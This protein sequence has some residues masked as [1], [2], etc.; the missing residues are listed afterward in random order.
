[1]ISVQLAL[2]LYLIGVL[3]V[4]AVID[5]RINKIPNSLT[6]PSIVVAIIIHTMTNGKQG[7]IFSLFGLCL[8]FLLL[9]IPYCLKVMSA[10]DVKLI[11]AVGAVLGLKGVFHAFLFTSLVGGIYSLVLLLRIKRPFKKRK[12]AKTQFISLSKSVAAEKRNSCFNELSTCV[13]PYGVVICL[14][15]LCSLIA[16]FYKSSITSILF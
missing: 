12:N 15:T 7:L 8:G 16:N 10:G 9:F 3:L 1:M 6:Y 5:A 4:A 14:G 2:H 11:A 13:L